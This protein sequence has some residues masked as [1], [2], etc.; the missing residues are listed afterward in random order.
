M[1]KNLIQG[2]P[3]NFLRKCFDNDF[4]EIILFSALFL[5]LNTFSGDV[6]NSGNYNNDTFNLVPV[7]VVLLFVFLF[8]ICTLTKTA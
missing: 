5:F 4:D 1:D 2:S 3:G 6:S 8:S 7:A